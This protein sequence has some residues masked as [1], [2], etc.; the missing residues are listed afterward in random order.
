MTKHHP[1]SVTDALGN[2]HDYLP[3]AGHD[4]LLPTYDLFTRLLGRTTMHTALVVQAELEAGQQ[5]LEIGCGTG[6]LTITAKRSQPAAEITGSDPDPLALARAQRKA[7]DLTGIRFERAYAQDLPY[8]DGSFD[9]VLSALMMHHL[10]ADVKTQAMQEVFRVLRPGGRL[11]IVDV[12][13]DVH[14]HR[15]VLSRLMHRTGALAGNL[16]DGIP[17]LLRETGFE[18]DVL[19]AEPRLA[20]GLLTYYR[21]TRPA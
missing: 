9:R 15:G 1:G 7:K 18:C 20:L 3:A 10:D 11:H 2:R 6:N 19:F 13:G 8:P 16:G 17:K 21:A 4:L 12:A 5:V 14:Q